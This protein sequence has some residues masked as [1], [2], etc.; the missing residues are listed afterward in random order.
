MLTSYGADSQKQPAF[1]TPRKY[2][3][4][5]YIESPLLIN[6]RKF[7]IRLWSLVSFDMKL[8]IFK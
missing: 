7:D 3:I 6:G 8:Y 2:I 1:K 5:K 4:Q